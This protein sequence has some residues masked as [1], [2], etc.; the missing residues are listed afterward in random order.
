MNPELQIK[1]WSID[2]M[3]QFLLYISIIFILIYNINLLYYI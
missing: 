3:W 1:Y 2:W